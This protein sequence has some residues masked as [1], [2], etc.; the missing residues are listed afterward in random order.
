MKFE[1]RIPDI[2]HNF[3]LH[4]PDVLDSELDS[5]YEPCEGDHPP[6]F[7]AVLEPGVGQVDLLVMVALRPRPRQPGPDYLLAGGRPVSGPGHSDQSLSVC[8]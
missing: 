8:C 5:G 4:L 2:V 3:L 1:S 6:V 7:G